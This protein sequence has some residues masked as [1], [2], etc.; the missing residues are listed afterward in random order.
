MK[1]YLVSIVLLVSFNLSAQF[2]PDLELTG[3]SKNAEINKLDID[4]AVI[5]NIAETT[6]D[7]TFYNPNDR[8]M[9]GTVKFPLTSDQ[10]IIE[11]HLDINGKLR[12]ASIVEKEKGR[13]AYEATIRQNIDPGLLEKSADNSFKARVFPI[14]AKGYKRAVFKIQEELK[15]VNGNFLYNLP[16][17]KGLKIP[18]F[19][20]NATLYSDSKPE[21]P[22]DLEFIKWQNTY[23]LDFSKTDYF[24]DRVIALKIPNKGSSYWKDE[25]TFY[26]SLDVE[27]LFRVKQTREAP[28]PVNITILWDISSSSDKRDHRLEYKFLEGYVSRLNKKSKI[29]I[30]PF[31]IHKY[32]SKKYNAENIE[33]I[34]DYIKDLNRDG[35]TRFNN[36]SLD[37]IKADRIL[38]FTDGVSTF[39]KITSPELPKIPVF[40][41]NSS[42]NSNTSLLRYYSVKTGGE[43]IDLNNSN[44]IIERP[45]LIEVKSTG[46]NEV[47]TDLE[48]GSNQFS[49]AGKLLD[50]NCKV[51]LTFLKT[52]GTK[53]QKTIE[54]KKD[55]DKTDLDLS[56]I[57][58]IKK[59][60][61]LDLLYD[62]NK[63]K[64]TSLGK[65]Y[66]IVTRN[67][68]L[69][70]L[71]RVEDYVRFDIDPPKDLEKEWDK[72]MAAKMKQQRQTEN[73][74]LSEA[75]NEM[76]AL[77]SWWD[78]D[79]PKDR[80]Q[81]P[82]QPPIGVME[83]SD[84]FGIEGESTPL[85]RSRES[86]APVADEMNMDM[87]PEMERSE[88]KKL[89]DANGVDINSITVEGWT[90]NAPYFKKIE[91]LKGKKLLDKY[92]KLRDEY[93]NRPSFFVDVATLFYDNGDRENA[94]LVIS[95]VIEMGLDEPELLRITAYLLEKF[96]YIQEALDISYKLLDIRGEEPQTYR[97]IASLSLL[98]SEYQNA[99]D[100][101]YKVLTGRWYPRFN[102]IK[103]VVLNEMNYLISIYG[104]RID[105]KSIDERLIYDMPLGVRAVIS[106]SS[107]NNDIDL[108]V[109]D[110]YQE[111]CGYSNK[112]TYTGGKLSSD[113]TGGYG[114]EEFTIKEPLFGA[115]VVDINFYSDN[116]M[117]VSGPVTI[118]VDIYRNY[119]KDVQKQTIIRRL[120]DVKERITIG[121]VKF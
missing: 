17:K 82:K 105:S 78:K 5:G 4:L 29:N 102:G 111:D 73:D 115:Y 49:V 76:A 97:D 94:L 42:F 118:K 8:I 65:K 87:S 24:L 107:N 85:M 92:Y 32:S 33:D 66:E 1:K 13:V 26:A 71:D 64:I 45:K 25:S 84:A 109:K 46:A 40:T 21:S 119:G 7:V 51:T 90:P 15:Y 43:Y 27:D 93:K 11:F 58:A 37:K 83:E 91:G 14:P 113:F 56:R 103:S 80:P 108:W 86:V 39:E 2:L 55:T 100:Y 52:D 3:I 62:I 44:R 101:Y 18:E 88:Q 19:S 72:L 10:E 98:N 48:V 61:S 35:G 120:A 22:K 77:K 75:L 28:K 112:L 110:P 68:S 41:I 106:W 54:V 117:S 31:N 34:I 79:F 95:N 59:I 38:L 104:N 47:F 9:E 53:V 99:L 23:T 81:P 12:K 30:V 96:G 121:K 69:I 116:R 20:L 114:P 50:N 63:D 57:W 74:N 6:V 89:K 67:T 16:M 70:V 60:E 36:L